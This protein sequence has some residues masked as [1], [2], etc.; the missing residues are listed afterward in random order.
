MRAYIEIDGNALEKN[1]LSI[2][3]ETGKDAIAVIK[4][5]AYGH[6]IIECARILFK[7][8][9]P[10]FATSTIEEA[11]SLRKSL[12]FTPI[13]LLGPS[14][15]FKTLSSYK[16]TVLV[17]GKEHFFSLLSSPYPLDIHFMFD[18]GM[19]REGIKEEDID[20]LLPLLKKSHLHL[21]GIATHYPSKEAY[22]EESTKF[23][24]IKEKFKK[25]G[26]IISHTSASSTYFTNHSDDTFYRVGLVLYG[27]DG[28]HEPVLS[29]KVPCIRKEK[30]EKGTHVGYDEK[31]II[32]EDGYL[33]TLAIGYADGWP[34]N[35]H[36]TAFFQGKKLEQIGLTCMDYLMVF[37]KESFDEKAIF[38][39]I[40]KEHTVNEIAQEQGTIPYEVTSRLSTR[41]KRKV[42]YKKQ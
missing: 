1:Y 7:Q 10:F 15:D 23:E 18:V 36:T 34:R 38:T 26:R 11:I 28:K 42:I 24:R 37:S 31:G 16:I 32:E 19:H 12:L 9:V 17:L 3:K 29:L 8:K 6:G 4:S 5:N 21:K 27:L 40:G 41:L 35:Y 39:L 33:Y 30:I 22:V 14:Y 2:K 20:E 13:L 25:I